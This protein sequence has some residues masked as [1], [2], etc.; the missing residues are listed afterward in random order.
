MFAV[1][2]FV[3]SASYRSRAVSMNSVTAT[4]GSR[5][6]K[7]KSSKV[8]LLDRATTH[9]KH[10]ELTGSQLQT[11]LEQAENEV[12]PLRT[13]EY[14]L[15]HTYSRASSRSSINEALTLGTAEQCH[16]TAVAAVSQQSQ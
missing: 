13:R 16:A 1:G 11:K 10:L 3:V 14:H 5:I 8:S 12:Q 9:V 6:S 7:Q 2:L 15:L 4:A